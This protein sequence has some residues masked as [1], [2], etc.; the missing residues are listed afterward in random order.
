MAQLD[1][2]TQI[3][4]QELN[5]WRN[6]H[7]VSG[8]QLSR[9]LGCSRQMICDVLAG[10]RAFSAEMALKTIQ[11][12][13]NHTPQPKTSPDDY[14]LQNAAVLAKYAKSGSRIK[15]FQSTPTK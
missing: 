2:E 10:R 9:I 12:L 11:I 7:N 8:S 14:A 3:F 13:R 5:E 6:A 1:K 15:Y 4:A